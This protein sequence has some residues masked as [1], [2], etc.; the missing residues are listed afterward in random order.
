MKTLEVR[1][2]CIVRNDVLGIMSGVYAERA[3]Q[4]VT[5]WGIMSGVY[6]EGAMQSVT[7]WVQRKKNK[8]RSSKSL[9]QGKF[10]LTLRAVFNSKF[11]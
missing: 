11:T 7:L 6:A 5:L 3:T 1:N 9:E 10:C 8:K 4:S 2:G